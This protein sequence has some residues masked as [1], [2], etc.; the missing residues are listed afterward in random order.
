MSVYW[1]KCPGCGKL[2]RILGTGHF[3]DHRMWNG[4]KM[5]PCPGSGKRRKA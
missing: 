2:R 5:V 3:A 4:K 1:A